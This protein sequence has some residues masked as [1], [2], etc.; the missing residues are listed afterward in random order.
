MRKLTSFAIAVV[1]ASV[2]AGM[3]WIQLG[4]ISKAVALTKADGYGVPSAPY[5][6]VQRLEP[7]Y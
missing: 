1:M 5:M 6:S 3:F 7:V 4:V 2:F